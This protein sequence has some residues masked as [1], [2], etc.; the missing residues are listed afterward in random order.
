MMTT[1]ITDGPPERVELRK[2]LE[3][4]P[5]PKTP[6]LSKDFEKTQPPGADE[7][8]QAFSDA[9]AAR[10]FEA[11]RECFLEE[12]TNW[13]D[14]FALTC[15]IRTF[16]TRKAVAAN[17]LA[18]QKLRGISGGFGVGAHQHPVFIHQNLVSHRDRCC[19]SK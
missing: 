9:F 16:R 1:D 14:Q 18:T 13:R 15:H 4:N 7:L 2:I 19:R 17:L 10:D 5:L 12:Q 3:E 11:L 6:T 8:I